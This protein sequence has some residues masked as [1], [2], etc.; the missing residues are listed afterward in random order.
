MIFIGKNIAGKNRFM[1]TITG[2]IIVLLLAWLVGKIFMPKT[3]SKKKHKME[4]IWFCKYDTGFK[5]MEI[6]SSGYFYF[7]IV[8]NKG[9]TK[10]YKGFLTEQI[11]DTI[12][13]IS[14]NNDT[15]LFH[16]IVEMNNKNLAL[17]NLQD[18]SIINFNK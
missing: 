12:K 16:R 13:A 7:D 4:G 18:S 14:F 8:V 3:F 10:S 2:S 11:S 15:L 1:I 9:I 5:R 17:K 6:K